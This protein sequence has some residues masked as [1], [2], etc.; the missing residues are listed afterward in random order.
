MNR[1]KFITIVGSSA[2][3]LAAAG[4]EGYGWVKTRRPDRALAPWDN[5]GNASYRDPRMKALSYAILAPNP[6]NRQPWLVDLKTPNRVVLYCDLER[7]LPQTDPFNRQI[8][9]GHGCFLELLDIAARELGF[10]V[11]ITPFPDGFSDEALDKRPIALIDFT[12]D[13]AADKDPLFQQITKRRTNKETYDTNRPVDQAKVAA[14]CEAVSQ[15]VSSDFT[16]DSGLVSRLRDLTL[17]AHLV[18]FTTPRTWKE[19]VDLMRIGKEEIERNPD[20]VDLGG[21]FLEGL[22]AL[23]QISREQMTDVNSTA[24]KQGLDIYKEKIASSM[25]F[26]WITTPTNTRFEQINAGR[27]WVRMNLKATELGVSVNPHSQALQEFPE[28]QEL[29]VELHQELHLESPSRLQ[30]FARIG[31]GPVV[32]VSPRW[33]IDSKIMT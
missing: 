16:L 11:T 23:G 19:T 24:F 7:L 22:S 2:I 5:A 33:R 26:V 28:M 15:G 21:A 31:Y 13:T 20:G 10:T 3:V 6:H 9:M 25:G 8:L 17:R 29:F 32:D 18:E 12:L 30:M 1:R 14:I 4:F 27:S